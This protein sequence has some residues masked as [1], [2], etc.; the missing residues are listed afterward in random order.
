MAGELPITYR[1]GLGKDLGGF[2]LILHKVP[3]I[4]SEAAMKFRHKRK[5][6]ALAFIYCVASLPLS[7]FPALASELIF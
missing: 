4:P 3:E 7:G 5:A 6:V 1:Y 2:Q